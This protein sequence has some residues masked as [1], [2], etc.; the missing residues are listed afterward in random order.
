MDA[1]CIDA[2]LQQPEQF[3]FYD[4]GG[5]DATFLGAAEVDS[6]GNV[7]VSKFGP[8]FVGPGGFI[9]IS[10]NSKKV[11][12][13]ATFTAGGL[14]V[15]IENEKLIIL[16]EGKEKKFTKKV[17]QITFGGQ[18]A[19]KIKLPVLYVTERCVFALREEGIELIEVAPALTSKN[20][21][22]PLW[23]L[24]PSSRILVS[25]I[26]GYSGSNPWG[27]IKTS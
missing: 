20:K 6:V 27:W 22:L 15:A 19:A 12:F 1:D 16:Q 4:G 13:V 21:S 26:R 7:N 11:I 23:I 17:Q 9:N 8:R 25:W 24:N 18:Y 2:L 5:L 10:Q 14:K 3:D